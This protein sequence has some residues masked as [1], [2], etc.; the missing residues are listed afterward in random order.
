MSVYAIHRHNLFQIKKERPCHCRARYISHLLYCSAVQ[1]PKLLWLSKYRPETVEDEHANQA[2]LDR[3]SAVGDLAMG[4]FGE[5]VEVPFGDLGDMINETERL[6]EAGT[7]V[8]TEA[9][10]SLDGL[11]CSVDILLNHGGKHV[12]M[13]EGKSPTH[14]SDI[15]R[16]DASFQYYVLTGLGYDVEKINLCCLNPAYV[17]QGPLELDKLFLLTDV[18]ADVQAM[19]AGVAERIDMLRT[20]MEQ[21]EE[22]PREIGE[23]CFSP[24]ACPCFGWCTKE[25]PKPNIFDIS[26]IQTRTK[27]ANYRKGIVSF[28]DIEAQKALKPDRLIEVSQAIHDLSPVID[29]EAIRDFL[30]QLT[31]PLYFLDFESFMPVVPL[32]DGCKPYEQIVFQYSLHFIEGEGGALRHR[33][34]LAYPGEDPRRGAAE[35]LCPDIPRDACVLA[36]NMSFE[37]TRIKGLAAL[38][39]DLAEHLMSIHDHIVDLMVPFQKKYY[40][41]RTM[42]GSYSIKHVLPALFPDDPS[43]DYHNLEGVHNGSEASETFENME[44][45]SPEERENFRQSLLKYCGLDTLAMVKV[46]EKLREVTQ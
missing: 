14:V 8:I 46:W 28:E 19:Q 4:L 12:S 13:V 3:G 26:G 7:P 18:T 43:L 20:Y 30:D 35:Q 15:N 36:Y 2:V 32:Y 37:K 17:R 9:S 38:Y 44:K 41:T 11:F 16:H 25:L 45:M 42:Q 27:L 24:Y 6:L 23:Q 34:Y 33:E 21:T 10:F 31:Y 29:R 5:Y 40:Y 1:C 22:P 39:P